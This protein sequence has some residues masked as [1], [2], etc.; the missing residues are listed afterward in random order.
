MGWK[1]KIEPQLKKVIETQVAETLR[2]KNAYESASSPAT[3]QIW[4]AL[5]QVMKKIEQMEARI[6]AKETAERI[7]K[8]KVSAKKQAK[9]KKELLDALENL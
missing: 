3:A 5:G 1:T 8:K 9:E 2:Y 6:V 7:K 4:I